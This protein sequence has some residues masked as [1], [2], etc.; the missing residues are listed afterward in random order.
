MSQEN[1]EVVR[2]CY[3]LMAKRDFS[4]FPEVAHPDLVFDLSRNVFNPGV[5]HGLDGL[6]R[7]VEQ[8]DDMWDEFE[9]RPEEFT[10]GGDQVVAAVRISGRGKGSGVAAEMQVFAVWTLH[11]G[12]V[13]Q[14]T[15]GYRDRDDA[16]EAAGLSE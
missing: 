10:D 7:F 1:V 12:R 9:I 3:E 13:V 8:V 14:V 6:Q 16:L 5:Y 2:R 15:G 4:A 11:E